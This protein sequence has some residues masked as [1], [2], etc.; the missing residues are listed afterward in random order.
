MMLQC[1]K[2]KSS[3]ILVEGYVFNNTVKSRQCKD[4]KSISEVLVTNY[5]NPNL[6]LYGCKDSKC[7]NRLLRL[8]FDESS[9]ATDFKPKPVEN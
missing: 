8:S 9:I 3:I 5:S 4:C 7:K 2:D 1:F 6:L